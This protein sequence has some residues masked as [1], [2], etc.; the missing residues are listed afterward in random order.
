MLE[1]LSSVKDGNASSPV[2]NSKKDN[3]NEDNQHEQ[4]TFSGIAIRQSLANASPGCFQ[5]I[6]N[7]I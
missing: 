2:T 4:K 6:H 1:K 3:E 5:F 7:G